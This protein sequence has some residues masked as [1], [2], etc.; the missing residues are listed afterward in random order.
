MGLLVMGAGLTKGGMLHAAGHPVSVTRTQLY[1]T[2]E[3]ATAKIVVFLEDLFL[4]HDLR[5]N[6][7]DFLEPNVIAQGIS[8]HKKFIAERFVLRDVSGRPLTGRVVDVQAKLPE[9]GVPLAELMAHQL[10]F[11]LEYEFGLP[12]EFLTI[13]QQFTDEEAILP[14]EMQV[15]LQ[16]EGVG[17]VLTVELRPGDVESVRLNWES[18]PLSQE[19]SDKERRQWEAQ[20]KAQTLGITSYS[21]VYS[22][23]YIDQSE[24]RHEILIPLLTLEQSVLLARNED[25]FFDLAEQ[26]AA[27]QQ[28]EAYFRTGNPIKIDGQPAQGVVQR[29]DFYGLDFRD[30]ARQAPRR[31]VPIA[32]ARVGII[33]SYACLQAPQTVQ[34]TW[35]RFN[36]YVYRVE[37]VVFSDDQ[38]SKVTLSRLG[39][40]NVLQ[41]TDA[42]RPSRQPLQPVAVALNAPQNIPVPWL[43]IVCFL[44]GTPL[45]WLGWIRGSKLWGSLL[46]IGFLI[47]AVVLWPGAIWEFPSPLSRSPRLSNS[48]AKAIFTSLHANIYKAF[49]FRQE[50]EIYDALA[51]SIQGDLLREVYLQIQEGLKM[52]EQGG[53]ISRISEVSLL[54]GEMQSADGLFDG[55]QA[56]A[57]RGRWNVAGTVEHWGH[58]HQR[59]NQYEGVFTIEAVDTAW[60]VTNIELLDQRRVDFQTR[61]RQLDD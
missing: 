28:I 44:L 51:V 9:E 29:C 56:F 13:S 61:L 30:F 31:S 52:Q 14:S 1:V 18:P 26:D 48:Q 53:A 16:Q 21:S 37:T 49:D 10:T 57:Y 38:V 46:A 12:P 36:N 7:T 58:I 20:Q 45:A 60:K 2:R 55:A 5:P 43:S 3:Q 42:G 25:P 32:S 24:V 6:D 54:E 22:F 23:L 19:A 35:N 59:T 41:W 27:R 39:G 40:E 47:F 17:E 11:E 34:L 33:L 50:S 4:F 15:V 8:L